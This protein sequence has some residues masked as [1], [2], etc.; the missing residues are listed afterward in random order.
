MGTSE[1]PPDVTADPVETAGRRMQCVHHIAGSGLSY[2]A[3]ELHVPRR[4]V[5]LGHHV[6]AQTAGVL[7]TFDDDRPAGAWAT[8]V[9]ALAVVAG[10]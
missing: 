9:T 3:R 7:N 4:V 2:R 1:K 8:A 5:P 6:H 10:A